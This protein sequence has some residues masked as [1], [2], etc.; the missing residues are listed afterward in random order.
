MFVDA[1]SVDVCLVGVFGGLAGFLGHVFGQSGQAQSDYLRLGAMMA[2]IILLISLDVTAPIIP[3]PIT[4]KQLITVTILKQV[5]II[6]I[7]PTVQCFIS[8]HIQLCSIRSF[9][10]SH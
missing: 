1:L 9:M 8:L 2:I 6:N 3:T 10:I 4:Y 7:L 5:F